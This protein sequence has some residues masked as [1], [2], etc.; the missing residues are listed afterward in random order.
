[1]CILPNF[2]IRDF[3]KLRRNRKRRIKKAAT[4]TVEV[5]VLKQPLLENQV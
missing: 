1:M 2:A 3:E 4:E 5:A